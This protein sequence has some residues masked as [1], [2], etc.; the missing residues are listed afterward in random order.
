M[1]TMSTPADPYDNDPRSDPRS[2]PQRSGSTATLEREELREEL[3][4]GDRERL[5]HY[6][7]KEKIMESALSGDPVIALCGKV[8]TPG[9]DPQKFPVC[10]ECKDIYNGMRP[11]KDDKDK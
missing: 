7:R 9:R 10:P 6:V 2:D 3:E 11:G 4:P 1:E 5:A 8:W